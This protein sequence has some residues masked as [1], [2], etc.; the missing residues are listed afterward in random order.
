[1]NLIKC[2]NLTKRYGGKLA[3]DNVDLIIEENNIVGL[4]GP[5][6]SGKTTIIKIINGLLSKTS[7]EIKVKDN[8]IGTETKKIISYLPDKNYLDLSMKVKDAIN[9]FKSFYEDFDTDK[10]YKL[11]NDLNIDD[12]SKLKTLS[13]GNLE[14]VELILVMSRNAD[15]YI[16]DEPIGGV[17]PASRDYILNTIL[18]N[19]KKGASI[20]IA[21][22]LIAD[23]ESI[24]DRVIFIKNGK[25]VLDEDAKKIKKERKQTIDQI[26][27]EEFKC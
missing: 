8:D 22:H 3:L 2:H 15:I 16:L 10:A 7:G 23:I 9:Y 19:Y 25:I 5:N 18:S 24:L 27:R 4:L 13:K 1:M 21:T 11:L 26:F 12:N 17:D 6:G 14:K 20:I